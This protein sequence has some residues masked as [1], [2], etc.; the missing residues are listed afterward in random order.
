MGS[1]GGGEN[2]ERGCDAERLNT[3]ERVYSFVSVCMCVFVWDRG[4]REI[5]R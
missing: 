4:W 2:Q 1:D 5:M 3:V